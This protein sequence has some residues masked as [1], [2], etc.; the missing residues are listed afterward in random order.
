MLKKQKAHIANV[1]EE[2]FPNMVMYKE[3]G[4]EKY[5]FFD[6][7][8]ISSINLSYLVDEWVLTIWMV[9]GTKHV[10]SKGARELLEKIKQKREE[11][12]NIEFINFNEEEQYGRTQRA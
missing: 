4:C 8:L 7:K 3:G 11:F 6:A 2:I 5:S 10:I 1:A 9:N 12:S